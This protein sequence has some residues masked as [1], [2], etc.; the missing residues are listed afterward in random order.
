M[1]SSITMTNNKLPRGSPCCT[2]CFDII[3]NSPKFNLDGTPYDQANQ[4]NNRG[5]YFV[6]AFIIEL[7]SILL[8]AFFKSNSN[9]FC[10][11][12]VLVLSWLHTWW[13]I[14]SVPDGTEMPNCT[15]SS[16]GETK[17][18][19]RKSTNFEVSLLKTSPQAI[20]R[21]SPLGFRR[22]S[23]LAPHNKGDKHWGTSKLA[24]FEVRD[25]NVSTSLLEPWSLLI[26]SKYVQAGSLRHLQRTISW[27]IVTSKSLLRIQKSS[28]FSEEQ[29]YQIRKPHPDGDLTTWRR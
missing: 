18:K 1:L 27:M 3:V 2:P 26:S 24:N 9:R 28:P 22:A 7:L 6:I 10:S 17:G 25:R 13:K 8:K 20:G 5:Q 15:G 21:G 4:R 23:N 19:A 29:S 12:R 11:S 16:F 14:I